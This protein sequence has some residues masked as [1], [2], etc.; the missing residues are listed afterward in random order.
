MRLTLVLLL[1]LPWAAHAGDC[2]DEAAEC[3][4]DCTVQFGGSIRDEMKSK[5]LKCVKKCAKVSG[6]CRERTMETKVN[7]LND[8]ALDRAPSTS[9]VDENG[10]PNLARSKLDP[11][12]KREAGKSRDSSRDDLRD[13]GPRAKADPPARASRDDAEPPKKA[14]KPRDEVR[15]DEVIKSDRTPLV[16]D[17]AAA[18]P[19]PVAS[20]PPV[21]PAPPKKE[22]DD[23]D[24][25]REP[26]DSKDR[27]PS[28]RGSATRASPRAP[29]ADEPPPPPKK[30]EPPAK[31][32]SDPPPPKRTDDDD[33]RNF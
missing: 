32:P 23:D 33:L 30:A 1:V 17:E 19:K 21:A 12:G 29:P 5:Y 24:W 16:S 18:P 22:R 20:N 8:G 26:K 13:D 2:E 3:Q 27:E 15:D 25:S 14:K 31:K 6:V 28:T 4:D 9:D 11:G 7:Q 10:M